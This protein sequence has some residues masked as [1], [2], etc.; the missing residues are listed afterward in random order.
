[1]AAKYI[2]LYSP[3]RTTDFSLRSSMLLTPIMIKARIPKTKPI[4]GLYS[5]PFVMIIHPP[6]VVPRVTPKL[7]NEVA[8]L[9]ANSNDCGTDEI[10]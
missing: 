8:R 9:L 5:T 4:H 7:P 10:I 1:M 3:H 2:R 6:T